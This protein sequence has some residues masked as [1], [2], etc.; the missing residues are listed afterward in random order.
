MAGPKGLELGKVGTYHGR[1]ADF[2]WHTS[3]QD[4][5]IKISPSSGSSLKAELYT[6]GRT[7]RV[8]F[9]CGPEIV[10]ATAEFSFDK[11]LAIAT[12]GYRTTYKE[13]SLHSLKRLLLPKIKRE[14]IEWD[15]RWVILTELWESEAFTTLIAG[16]QG[17]E[18]RISADRSIEGAAF[19]VANLEIG[20]KLSG[21]S[22]MTYQGVADQDVTPFFQIHKVAYHKPTDDLYFKRYG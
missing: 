21:S 17:S 10:P 11:K 22:R 3:L 18:A 14:E 6:T 1:R 5:G 2:S 19:N 4:L 16:S 13:L 9:N 8:Q 12:Q 15:F 20:V 7:V